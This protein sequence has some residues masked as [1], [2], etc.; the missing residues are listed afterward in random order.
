MVDLQT[1]R[2]AVSA[3]LRRRWRSV[4]PGQG[5]GQLVGRMVPEAVERPTRPAR[6]PVGAP[7]AAPRPA[8]PTKL[9][10]RSWARTP[11]TPAL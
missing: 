6:R 8:V 9:R 5:S 3:S 10:R 11:S 7:E 2:I 4:I 1:H